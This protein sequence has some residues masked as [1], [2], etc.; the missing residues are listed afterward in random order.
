M[1]LRTTVVGNLHTIMTTLETNWTCEDNIKKIGII[2]CVNEWC[3]E[4]T[5]ASSLQVTMLR[6]QL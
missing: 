6:H 3:Y 2:I 4:D 5:K 1:N